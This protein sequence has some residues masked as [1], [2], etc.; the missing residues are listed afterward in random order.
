MWQT[1]KIF[2]C[3][4]IKILRDSDSAMLLQLPE[5]RW[6]L[7]TSADPFKLRQTTRFVQKEGVGRL[8]TLVVSGSKADAATVRHLQ[9]S[10]HPQYTRGLCDNEVF[11]PVGQGALRI[12]QER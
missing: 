8:H 1:D 5:N 10:F 2:P 12:A 11:W 9:E 7:V 6:V 3:R 4:D